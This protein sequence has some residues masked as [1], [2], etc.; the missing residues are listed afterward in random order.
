MVNCFAKVL[1]CAVFFLSAAAFSCLILDHLLWPLERT[2]LE[3]R[4]RR[5]WA[6]RVGL[7]VLGREIRVGSGDIKERRREVIFGEW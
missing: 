4:V 1:R 5:H 6:H 2:A 3:A 7:R